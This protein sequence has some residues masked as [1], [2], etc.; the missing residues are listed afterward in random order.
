MESASTIVP[1][2]TASNYVRFVRSFH[3][4]AEALRRWAYRTLET[5]LSIIP[6]IV[7]VPGCKDLKSF[8]R[9]VECSAEAICAHISSCHNELAF[10]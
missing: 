8:L 10:P 2:R 5:P 3:T 9:E 1:F 6:W 4:S 7:P